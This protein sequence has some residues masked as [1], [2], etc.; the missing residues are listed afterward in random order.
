MMQFTCDL[1]G[2]V[3]P[4]ERYEAKLTVSAAFD[5]DELTVADLDADHLEAIAESLD[6]LQDTGEFEIEE[7]GPREFRFDLCSNCARKY[8]QDPLHREAGRRLKFS[9]N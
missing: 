2:R 8:V 7:T 9:K 6:A 3:I 4:R 1:C 5:P